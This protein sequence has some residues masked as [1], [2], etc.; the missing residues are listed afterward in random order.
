MDDDFSEISIVPANTR[1]I[2]VFRHFFDK[3]EFSE[4]ISIKADYPGICNRYKECLHSYQISN[5]VKIKG[6][7]WLKC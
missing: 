7:V 3:A 4:I 1:K 5:S 2:N 6:H